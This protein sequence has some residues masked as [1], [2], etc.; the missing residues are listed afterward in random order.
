[1]SSA[2]H[3]RGLAS[4]VV[5]LWS[6]LALLMSAPP[7]PA[8][9]REDT[10]AMPIAPLRI[11][12]RGGEIGFETQYYR[13]TQSRDDGD[14]LRFTHNYFEEYLMYRLRGYVYHPRF[15]DF[16]ARVKLGLTQQRFSREGALDN[17]TGRSNET[18]TG[19]DIYLNFLK[20]HPLSVALYANR[21]RRA[22]LQ[23]FTDRQMVETENY[24]A[25]LNW[26]K[27][28]F[29][30]DI[31]VGRH[32]FR[33]WG[34][35]SESESRTDFFQWVVRNQIGERVRSELRYRWQDYEQD[36]AARGPLIDIRRRTE[37]T[38]HDVSFN[39]I[40]YLD[41]K[42]KSSLNSFLRYF[43]QD[44]TQEQESFYWLE[45]LQL[46]HTPRLR[47]YYQASYL[48]N[49]F[50]DSSVDTWTAEAGIE[51][52][53]YESLDE[54]LDIHWR[55]TDFDSTKE[56]VYGVTGRLNYRKIT[57][58]GLLT[59]GYGLTVDQYQ[60]TGPSG[61]QDVIDEPLTL[62]FNFTAFLSQTDVK[63]GSIT[64]TDPTGLITY[65]EGFDYLVEERDGRTGLRLLPGGRLNEGDS[66]LVDYEVDFDSSLEY[67]AVD[68][69]FF[70][71][72]DFE[73]IVPRLALYYRWRDLSTSGAPDDARI[74]EYTSHLFGLAY[75]WKDLTWTEEFEKYESNFSS[76]DQLKSQ[77]EGS[78]RLWHSVRAGW[79]V[80]YLMIDYD[81]GDGDPRGDSSDILYAGANL[82]GRIKRTGFWELTARARRETGRT[83]ETLLGLLA[84]VG[85]RWRKVRFE[86]GVRVE[87]HERFDS[88]RDRLHVYMSIAREF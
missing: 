21:E 7:A 24:G 35:E 18:L 83:E 43:Q 67:V 8:P 23:L 51:H 47:T 40:V 3:S 87:E 69:N 77:I 85:G 39:N 25:T 65:I 26:K 74:L 15:L 4:S 44:G 88:T 86:A 45:R 14:T 82:N 53:L 64:V 61:G 19:F 31:A 33:E 34:F 6:A 57:A 80:G 38:S 32:Q 55:R 48:Q 29:P 27:G 36:F 81:D 5:L 10:R 78:H 59:A 28:P 63:S 60:R 56:D 2:D 66:V 75:R 72:H 16:R 84:R 42:K 49:S 20:E 9:A 11:L 76:Y 68:Q 12:E 30:M 70:I 52:K 46:Q 1:M 13:E 79:N 54:H 22:V 71:R 50:Q 58:W 41:G 17:D 62:S 73:R 37:L